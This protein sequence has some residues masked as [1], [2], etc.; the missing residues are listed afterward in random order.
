ML[1][2]QQKKSVCRTFGA[3][4]LECDEVLKVGNSKD[5]DPRRLPINGLRHRPERDTT[6]WYIWSGESFSEAEDFFVPLHALQL[7]DLCQRS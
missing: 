4:F 6:G 2:D 7:R 3:N 1:S 5:F